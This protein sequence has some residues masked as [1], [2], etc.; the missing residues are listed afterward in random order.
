[1]PE[2]HFREYQSF[3]N[4]QPFGL[5]REDYR[6]AQISHLLAMI[7]RDPKSKA[8][9]LTEFMPFYKEKNTIDDEDDGSAAYLASR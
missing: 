8:M 1:M 5:W 2:R 7:N 9:E 4:E 3:Y 6:T